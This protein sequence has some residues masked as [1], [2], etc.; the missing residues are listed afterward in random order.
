MQVVSFFLKK[1][2]IMFVVAAVTLRHYLPFY[3]VSKAYCMCARFMFA[4]LDYPLYK[5]H[6]LCKSLQY[7]QFL[8]NITG[9]TS[10]N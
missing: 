7:K 9:F 5:V 3:N 6:L 4:F 8:L 1:S 2:Y 10:T